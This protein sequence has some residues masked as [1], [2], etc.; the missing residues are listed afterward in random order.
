MQE[1]QETHKALDDLLKDEKSFAEVVTAMFTRIDKDGSGTLEVDEVEDFIFDIC[2][3]MGI[4]QSPDKAC[5]RAIFE[6]LDE[7]KSNNISKDELA[8]FVKILFEEQRDQLAKQI[9]KEKKGYY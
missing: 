6:E 7:D 3:E 4:K 5:V 2:K 8:T 1:L 9:K